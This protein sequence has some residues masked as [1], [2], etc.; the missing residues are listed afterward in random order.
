MKFFSNGRWCVTLADPETGLVEDH[1]GG[2]YTL[3]G[4]EYAESVTYATESVR[5]LLNITFHFK[6]RVDGDTLTQKGT[7]NNFNEVWKRVKS[8]K[9]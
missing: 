7:D 5:S 4:N 6:I 9:R 1:H 3:K 2:T 8:E